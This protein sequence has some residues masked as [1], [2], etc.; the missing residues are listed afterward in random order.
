VTDRRAAR[1][2]GTHSA[3][4]SGGA[5]RAGASRRI[6]GILI[7][8]AGGASLCLA[9]TRSSSPRAAEDFSGPTR[10]AEPPEMGTGT[11]RAPRAHNEGRS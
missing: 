5:R 9:T 2:S 10:R 8:L 11:S 7:T 1:V 4:D 3:A 6:G